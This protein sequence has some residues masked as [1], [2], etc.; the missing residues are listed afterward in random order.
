MVDEKTKTAPLTDAGLARVCQMMGK[1]IFATADAEKVHLLEN[2]IR[3]RAAYARDREYVLRDGR[4]VLVDEFTGRL[5]TGRRLGRGLH[6]AIEAKE[7]TQI[8]RESRTVATITFQNYFRMYG[9][10]AGMT[11]TAQDRRRRV[12]EHLFIRSKCDSAQHAQRAARRGRPGVVNERAKFS[13]HIAKEAKKRHERGQPVL[14]GTT[15][16]EKSEALAALLGKRRRAARGAERQAARARGGDYC[17]RGAP[18][19]G[20]DC[21]EYGG[22]GHRYSAGRGRCRAGRADGDWQ[23]AARKP[24]R[25]P[26]AARPRRPPGRPWRN[27]VFC[28][29]GRFVAATIWV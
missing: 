21:H 3:A 5:M 23:R 16:I 22:A 9:R 10:L 4:V 13:A 27:A 11:G 24:P 1:D 7:G 2:A 19:R 8:Q 14:I 15:S 29:A 12:F 6:Q 26:A 18:R 17:A 28:F 25:R 20:D